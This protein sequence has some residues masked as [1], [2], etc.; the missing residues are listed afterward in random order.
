MTQQRG[1][2]SASTYSNSSPETDKFASASKGPDSTFDLQSSFYLEELNPFEPRPNPFQSFL[3]SILQF[4]QNPPQS[5][6]ATAANETNSVGSQPAKMAL[7]WEFSRRREDMNWFVVSCLAHLIIN[8]EAYDTKE[9]KIGFMLSLLNKG[10]AGAWKEQFIQ[11]AYNAATT[12]D[13]PMTFGT[14]DNF[15][16][17]LKATFQPHND[18]ADALAQLRALQYNL[19]E[20]IDEHITK[21]KM[22]LA[23]TKLDKSDD[24]QATIVFF[25]ETLPPWLI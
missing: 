13:T 10:E 4:S 15:L 24:S 2:Y 8:K 20:N 17:N 18:P 11:A 19:G 5:E 1:H 3:H 25:K 12:S 16:C 14:F 23:Q 21:F 6:M 9:K 7:P 22:A